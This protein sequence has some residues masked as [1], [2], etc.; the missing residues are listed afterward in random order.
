MK[1]LKFLLFLSGFAFLLAS[2][3]DDDTMDTCTQESWI[4][5]YNLVGEEICELDEDTELEFDPIFVVEAGSTESS[6][7][8]NGDEADFVECTL[9]Q[10]LTL[11]LN[12]NTITV[13]FGTC[14]RDYVKN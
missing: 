9:T 14:S 12:G 4:G 5:T 6:V 7:V 13:D 10:L 1:N 11:T 3:G 8:I 2:C